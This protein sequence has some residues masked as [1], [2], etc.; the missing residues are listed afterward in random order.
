MTFL[1][2]IEYLVFLS[3]LKVSNFAKEAEKTLE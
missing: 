3:R 1:F 2:Q